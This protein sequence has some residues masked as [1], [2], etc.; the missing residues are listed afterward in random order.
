M[1]CELPV[2]VFDN[3]VNREILGNLGVYAKLGDPASLAD[4]IEKLLKD[5][6]LRVKLGHESRKRVISHLGWNKSANQI[7]E[8]YDSLIKK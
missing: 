1:S 8:V 4:R 7:L 2:V 5:N 3:P 6:T